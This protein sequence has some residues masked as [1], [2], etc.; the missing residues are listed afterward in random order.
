MITSLLALLVPFVFTGSCAA[1]PVAFP[2]DTRLGLPKGVVVS[3]VV[4]P[5]EGGSG[6]PLARWAIDQDGDPWWGLNERTLLHLSSLTPLKFEQ[7]VQDIAWLDTGE[8]VAC[9]DRSLALADVV[10]SR[11]YGDAGREFPRVRLEPI[12]NL[13]SSGAC[14]LF[15]GSGAVLYLV[16]ADAASGRAAAYMLRKAAGGAGDGVKGLFSA[17]SGLGGLAG[18]GEQT[19]VALD[20]KIFRLR[21]RNRELLFE[22]PRERVRDL[23]WS[24][25][26]GLFY[27]TDSEVGFVGEKGAFAFMESPK[28]RLKVRGD[29]LYALLPARRGI[30]AFFGLDGFK[31]R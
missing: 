12:L 3:W 30:L 15:P 8:F 14:R 9:T 26:A 19:F 27:A 22:H 6:A 4:P 13:P 25:E 24:P 16:T 1:Q 21:G 5:V 20:Q 18:D 23:A 29:A 10:E 17:E 7:P 11:A 28:V 2:E 31:R